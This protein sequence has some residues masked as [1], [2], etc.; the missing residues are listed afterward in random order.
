LAGSE[1]TSAGSDA[2]M[3]LQGICSGASPVAT[4]TGALTG[5]GPTDVIGAVSICPSG[6][7]VTGIERH[8]VSPGW[9]G[10]VHVR[11]GGYYGNSIHASTIGGRGAVSTATAS[12]AAPMVAIALYG[13]AGTWLDAVGLLCAAPGQSQNVPLVGGSGGSPQG[14]F[15]C[16]AGYA[17]IGVQGS[18]SSTS[19]SGQDSVATLKGICEK[20]PT[21]FGSARS[22]TVR[23]KGSDRSGAVRFRMVIRHASVL[24]KAAVYQ[25]TL[26][27]LSFAT[28][29]S[30]SGRKIPGQV[31]ATGRVSS[32]RQQRFTLRTKRYRLSGRISGPLAKPKV[33]GTLKVLRGTCG[34]EVLPFRAKI[35]G[36]AR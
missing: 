28:S 21:T 10:G 4:A 35:A 11:C 6:T 8:A 36:R 26:Y 31:T 16:T 15:M 33:R 5:T 34:G 25:Y 3:S 18:Y 1:L 20:Y 13:R 7:F 17:L 12:C 23:Y 14:P 29:C 24:G 22:K 19:Y 27:H 9:T 2:L 30:P 32:R